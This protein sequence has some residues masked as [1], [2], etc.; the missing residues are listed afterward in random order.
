MQYARRS[1]REE[2]DVNRQDSAYAYISILLLDYCMIE[3]YLNG[4]LRAESKVGLRAPTPR[5]ENGF[6]TST[7]L[8]LYFTLI[9]GIVSL[10]CITSVA[11]KD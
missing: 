4:V 5:T 1:D 9:A 3:E 2:P 8:R 6:N 10:L 7:I 11:S